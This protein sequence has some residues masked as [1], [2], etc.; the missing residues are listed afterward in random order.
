MPY[1]KVAE[2]ISKKLEELKV[3]KEFDFSNEKEC[4]AP[5]SV[6]MV[7]TRLFPQYIDHIIERYFFK[8]AKE[9]DNCFGFIPT[10]KLQTRDGKTIDASIEHYFYLKENYTNALI[11]CYTLWYA[12][13]LA[14]G[15]VLPTRK[16]SKGITMDSLIANLDKRDKIMNGVKKGAL[17]I[18]SSEVEKMISLIE[19]DIGKLPLDFKKILLEMAIN[20][21]LDSYALAWIEE[22]LQPTKKQ[23]KSIILPHRQFMEMKKKKAWAQEALKNQKK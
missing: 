19:I 14:D 6:R 4:I 22:D 18:I 11:N 10:I 20:T 3:S 5:Q 21:M 8:L 12:E 15:F 16:E 1:S 7:I 13:R 9:C 17:E 23:I 2:K